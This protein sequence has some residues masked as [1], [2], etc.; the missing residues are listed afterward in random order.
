MTR[1]AL[2]PAKLWAL[3]LRAKESAHEMEARAIRTALEQTGWRV[4][5][6]ARLLRPD[7]GHSWLATLL[8]PGGRHMNLGDE[9]RRR[10]RAQGYRAGRPRK[11]AL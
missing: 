10:D 6:A 4:K 1:R 7:M 3:S 2:D 9:L 8:G 5:P 11:E